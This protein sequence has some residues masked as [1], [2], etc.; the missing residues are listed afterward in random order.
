MK[1]DLLADLEYPENHLDCTEEHL[2]MTSFIE[3]STCGRGYYGV[4]H[5]HRLRCFGN[6]NARIASTGYFSKPP[7]AFRFIGLSLHGKE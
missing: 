1:P 2:Q 4:G 5:H 6:K 7:S 3:S